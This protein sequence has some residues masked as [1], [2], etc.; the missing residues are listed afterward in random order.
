M[1]VNT[2]SKVISV[3]LKCEITEV[4][5]NLVKCELLTTV[6]RIDVWVGLDRICLTITRPSGHIGLGLGCHIYVDTTTKVISGLYKCEKK[7]GN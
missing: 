5:N 6:R 7:Q 1:Y 2:T 4:I 3:T